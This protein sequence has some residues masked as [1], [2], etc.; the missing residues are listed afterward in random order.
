MSSNN[1]SKNK[2]RVKRRKFVKYFSISFFMLFS[3]IAVAYIFAFVG[4]PKVTENNQNPDNTDNKTVAQSKP[5]LMETLFGPKQ[6]KTNVAVFGTDKGSFR[7]DTIMVASFD[8]KT[9]QVSIISIPRD[10][11]VKMTDKMIEDIRSGEN[12]TGSLPNWDG[13]CKINEI[14]SYAGKGHRNEYSV[15]QLEDLL[16]IK[17]D[18]Y[19]KVDLDAFKKIVEIVDGV[20]FEV[21]RDMNYDDPYQDL[22]I[23]LKAGMQHLGPEEAEAVMRWRK[24]NNGTGYAE[25]DL[26]RIETQQAF[27]KALADKVLNTKTILSNIPELIKVV[28]DYVETDIT[29]TDALKYV[30]YVNDITTDNIVMEMLPGES[31]WIPPAP[32]Y[33]IYDEIQTR[34][35]VD[36]IFYDLDESE[37]RIAEAETMSSKNKKIEVLNGGAAKGMASKTRTKLQQDGFNV[38]S[39]GDYNGDRESQTVIIVNEEGLGE[40]LEKYFLNSR[41]E[42]AS[43]KL[44]ETDIRI[45]L[46]T[47]EN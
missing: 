24:N 5:S 16:G 34:A 22:S 32:S 35:L 1:N 31:E 10:T 2:K 18:Y 7:T 4:K 30:G 13:I 27:I 14:H 9:K 6:V 40:D 44:D 17:I 45:I 8:S 19:V 39:I 37:T 12:E 43:S 15:M 23:H 46:G 36:K 20:D 33:F 3:V 29:I 41:I 21:P 26:G 11:K 38:V 42:V 28:W 25:G 47:N